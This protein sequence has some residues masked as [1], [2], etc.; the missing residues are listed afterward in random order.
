MTEKKPPQTNTISVETE[1][2]ENLTIADIKNDIV[3]CQRLIRR[4]D[5]KIRLYKRKLNIASYFNNQKKSLIEKGL[6]L[7]NLKKNINSEI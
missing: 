3:K 1:I 2:D 4:S 5:Y 6:E 7:F